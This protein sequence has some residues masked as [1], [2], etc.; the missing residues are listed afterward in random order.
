MMPMLET[1]DIRQVISLGKTKI[2]FIVK[3]IIENIAS[4]MK[5]I[6]IL[7]SFKQSPTANWQRLF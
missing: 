2:G 3:G 4:S 7:G 5:A 1:T 6:P